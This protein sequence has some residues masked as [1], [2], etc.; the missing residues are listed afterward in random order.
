MDEKPRDRRISTF[1]KLTDGQRHKLIEILDEHNA[2]ERAIEGEFKDQSKALSIVY[3]VR[4][5]CLINF[6]EADRV[7]W[8]CL[9][10]VTAPDPETIEMT[11][12]QEGLKE[13]E[14]EKYYPI[15]ERL[16]G[17][18]GRLTRA[19]PP[20]PH[21]PS[22]KAGE[23]DKLFAFTYSKEYWEKLDALFYRTI[24]HFEDAFK[25]NKRINLIVVGLGVVFAGYGVVYSAYKGLDLFATVFGAMGL[26]T[27]L[28]SFLF[29]PQRE[30][31][32]N[33]GDLL[34]CQLMY[35]TYCHQEEAVLDW[36]RDKRNSLSLEELEKANN[37]L[38]RIT[39]EKVELIE[40]LIGKELKPPS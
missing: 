5:K 26:G 33:V 12:K 29:S 23:P 24:G 20:R 16:E 9:E 38:E 6:D 3:E 22:L 17:K 31:Q 36:I 18:L 19:P 37:H 35:R 10:M 21:E 15:F 39:K 30:I 28:L 4:D 11:L 8:L 14:I 34:Q 25:T 40:D 32:R 27:S 2:F 1:L 7:I 13:E